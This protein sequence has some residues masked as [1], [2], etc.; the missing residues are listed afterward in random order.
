MPSCGGSRLEIVK[1]LR[2]PESC[3][4]QGWPQY[5]ASSGT[6]RPKGLQVRKVIGMSRQ[7]IICA[8]PRE[9]STGP[10][11]AWGFWEACVREN[12]PYVT[13]VRAAWLKGAITILIAFKGKKSKLQCM[14]LQVRVCALP[15][16]R[17]G[18][19]GK[20]TCLGPSATQ[21]LKNVHS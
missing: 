2:K 14:A 11:E 4:K 18:A 3:P 13:A 6:S 15:G 1:E 17:D 9:C 19:A 12:R 7:P 20:S 10:A 8:M 21:W 16:P 5:T